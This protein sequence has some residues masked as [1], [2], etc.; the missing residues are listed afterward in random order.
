[1]LEFHSFPETDQLHINADEVASRDLHVRLSI[2]QDEK[3][4]VFVSRRATA[5]SCVESDVAASSLPNA[6]K[7]ALK[8]TSVIP[9]PQNWP[10]QLL[11][12]YVA[13]NQTAALSAGVNYL[14]NSLPIA[15]GKVPR[16]VIAL[17]L[18]IRKASLIAP[19][20]S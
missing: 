15:Q 16:H 14:P 13:A 1:M 7:R 10:H 8:L 5:K 2:V 9:K 6:P 17:Q 19:Q 12:C 18:Q 20:S 4:P 3:G 11:F